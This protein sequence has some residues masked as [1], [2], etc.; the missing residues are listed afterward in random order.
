MS[1]LTIVQTAARLCNIQPI[2]N[3]AYSSSDATI[4]QLV[5]LISQTGIE[6]MERGSWRNLK[7]EGTVTGDGVSTEFALPADWQRLCPTD[8]P[9]QSPF[10]SLARPTIPILGPVSDEDLNIRKALP[11]AGLFPVW[12]FI[13]GALEFWP[14]LPDAETLTFWYYSKNWV[15]SADGTLRRPDWAADDDVSLI[16]ENTVALGAV[17]RY[18]QSK[19]L[20]YA[21]AFRAYEMSFM[22]NLAQEGTGRTVSMTANRPWPDDYWPGVITSS[23]AT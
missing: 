17:W 14:A 18:K 1:L 11:L 20:D 6:L 15:L 2:P 13:G 12:R 23:T 3:A 4:Q 10:V 16:N 22:R 5:A 7:I 19:G 9:Q 21:E 8:S